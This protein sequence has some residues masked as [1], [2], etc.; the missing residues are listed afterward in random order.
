MKPDKI[1]EN[2]K[3][4]K[5]DLKKAVELLSDTLH[6]NGVSGVVGI[7][8]LLT[9]LTTVCVAMKISHDDFIDMCDCT[10]K[11]ASEKEET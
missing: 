8:A 5:N 9:L 11:V 4:Y 10:Y 2:K 7:N 1:S 3:N 6:F